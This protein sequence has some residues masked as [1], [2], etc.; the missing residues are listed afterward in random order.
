MISKLKYTNVRIEEMDCASDLNEI[1]F[2]PII[3]KNDI[4]KKYWIEIQSQRLYLNSFKEEW[5]KFE[6]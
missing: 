3:T 6:K 2:K 5:I 1:A 4:G